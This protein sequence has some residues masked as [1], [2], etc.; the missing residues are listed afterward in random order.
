V[1]EWLP[2]VVKSL[3]K[4]TR[5]YLGRFVDPAVTQDYAQ[6]RHILVIGAAE[7]Y[8][9]YGNRDLWLAAVPHLFDGAC[10]YWWFYWDPATERPIKFTCNGNP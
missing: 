1:R 10:S 7:S 5:Y 6:G 3:S 8:T 4:F 2:D 9:R